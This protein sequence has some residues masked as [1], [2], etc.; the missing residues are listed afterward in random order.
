MGLG[1]TWVDDL[2]GLR[3]RVDMVKIPTVVK[4]GQTMPTL[5]PQYVP[6][7]SELE[8]NKPLPHLPLLDYMLSSH[9]LYPIKLQF[10]NSKYVINCKHTFGLQFF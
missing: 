1:D 6:H 7:I 3:T 10:F 9:F 5:P 4:Y 8:I 2:V